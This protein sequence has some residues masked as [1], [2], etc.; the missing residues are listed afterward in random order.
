MVYL[1]TVACSAM[2]CNRNQVRWN[3][4]SVLHV[5]ND[6]AV[7]LLRRPKQK[8]L[9]WWESCWEVETAFVVVGVVLFRLSP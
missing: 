9:N 4:G 8:I 3:R 6:A 1:R 2:F 7:L 5:S